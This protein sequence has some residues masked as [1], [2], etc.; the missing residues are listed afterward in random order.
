MKKLSTVPGTRLSRT[1]AKQVMGGATSV[2]TRWKCP[3]TTGGVIYLCAASEPFSILCH[4]ARCTKA[5]TCYLPYDLC[6]M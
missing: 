3:T 4:Y 5:G 6:T 1:A 2:R